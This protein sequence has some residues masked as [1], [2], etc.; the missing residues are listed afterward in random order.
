M[1]GDDESAYATAVL[2]NRAWKACEA[3]AKAR[4]FA[5]P[6]EPPGLGLHGEGGETKPEFYF[7]F[8]NTFPALLRDQERRH[9]RK[10]PLLDPAKTAYKEER[11]EAL[12]GQLENIC[13]RPSG[14]YSADYSVSGSLVVQALVK[15]GWDAV[16]PLLDCYEHDERLTG[17]IPASHAGPRADLTIL[18]VRS[19]AYAALESLIET[20][21]FAPPYSDRKTARE[22]EAARTTSA[23]GVRKYWDKYRGLSR[24]ERLFAI[25]RDDNGQWLEAASIM[26]QPTNKPV[27]PLVSWGYPWGLPLDF[28]DATR[29]LGEPLRV[30]ENPSVTELLIKRVHNTLERGKDSA[31]DAGALNGACNLAF[32]LTKWDGQA[33]LGVL[34]ELYACAFQKLA[35]THY[36]SLCSH[37]DLA[38][39]LS[40]MVQLRASGRVQ[41][42]KPTLFK[43][44]PSNL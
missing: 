19:A 31:D 34:Q 7:P 43:P 9:F 6:P 30:K 22:E 4:G 33:G 41:T 25:L 44:Q 42:R 21:Q 3:E 35:P 1:R 27:M 15:E 39:Q 29:M 17:V 20:P 5:I 2:L 11:I 26:V 38:G 16:G 40:A 32:C 24:D 18:D 10:A 23:Q 37:M 8:L 14:R 36:S 12:I 28:A 13:A